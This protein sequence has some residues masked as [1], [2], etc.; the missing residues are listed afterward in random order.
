MSLPSQILKIF[1]DAGYRSVL[2][3]EYEGDKHTAPEGVR[4]TK[5]LLERIRAQ[6]S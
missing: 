3:I 1:K 6:T 5:A 4:L 2:G